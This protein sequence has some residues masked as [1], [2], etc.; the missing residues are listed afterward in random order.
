[1]QLNACCLYSLCLKEPKRR[2]TQAC[3][4]FFFLDA[5]AAQ[6]YDFEDI[7]GG[8]LRFVTLTDF[9]VHD[10]HVS[11]FLNGLEEDGTPFETHSLPARLSDS[12]EDSTMRVGLSSKGKDDSN[13]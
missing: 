12:N 13:I 3:F 1:M 10:R 11:L 6:T 5:V 8:Q 9:Q 4:F 2:F 7:L